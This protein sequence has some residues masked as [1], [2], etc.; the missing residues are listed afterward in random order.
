[1]VTIKGLARTFTTI[2]NPHSAVLSKLTNKPKKIIFLNGSRFLITWSQFRFLR[3]HYDLLKKY[4]LQQIDA[5]TFKI[6]T[7]R[8]QLIGSQV[9]ICI[10]DE[11]ESGM[12]E[13]D[14][15]GKVV[16]DIG[17]F[18]GD[19][20]VFFWAMGA[21]KVIIYEPVLE[22]NKFILENVRLNNINAEI[23]NEG[24]GNEDG[25]VTVAYEK[26]DNCFG[27]EAESLPN[28]MQIKIKDVTKVISESDADVA[29]ID[30]EGAE[31]SLVNV[32][33]E[34]LRKI[35]YAIIE[36]HTL[37]IRERLIQKFKSA[38]FI[39]AKGNEECDEPISMLY[40]K[41]V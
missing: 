23:H 29:K 41:R 25:E 6:N 35:E 7:E 40:F 39:M 13:Y 12:Y 15:K 16:L 19:S 36:V 2:K 18:E 17:G 31:V 1:M 24:I 34:I 21:K 4:N 8:F 11:I 30:C 32:P 5:E 26:V 20:A 10:L 22:H 9:L 33:S 28:K 37:Q 27:L 38:G 3:D 14:C